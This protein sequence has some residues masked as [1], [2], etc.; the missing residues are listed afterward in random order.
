M[1]KFIHTLLALSIAFAPLTVHAGNGAPARESNEIR[2]ADYKKAVGNVTYSLQTLPEIINDLRVA[3]TT[4]GRGI[5]K[6][7]SQEIYTRLSAALELM[8]IVAADQKMTDAEKDNVQRDLFVNIGQAMYRMLRQHGSDYVNKGDNIDPIPEINWTGSSL[9]AKVGNTLVSSPAVIWNRIGL[10]TKEFLLDARSLGTFVRSGDF[11]KNVT[12]E[13]QEAIRRRD[14]RRVELEEMV[15]DL[16]KAGKPEPDSMRA[17][18]NETLVAQLILNLVNNSLDAV[19]GEASAWVRVE[20]TEDRDSVYISVMDSGPG[21]PIKIRSRIFDPFFTTKSP[22]RGT[23]L[24]L[25]LAT[26]IAV[27]HHGSLRLDTLATHT[28]FVFQLPKVSPGPSP[29]SR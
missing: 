1:K 7:S 4:A 2:A 27:H 20:F 5:T 23:G 26:S 21:I 28:R 16:K 8:H 25:S 12:P 29:L 17:E 24:G 3:D 9:A 19:Q 22:G 10:I 15:G 14:A 18:M 6:T 11:K 13:Q